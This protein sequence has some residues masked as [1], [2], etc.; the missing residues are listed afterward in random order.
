MDRN[1]RLFALTLLIACFLSSMV[2]T[3]A[4]AGQNQENRWEANSEKKFEITLDASPPVQYC[5]SRTAIQYYQD[6][7]NAK[8][9]GEINIDG[10]TNASGTY[11]ISVRFRD[12]NGKKR[13][14]GRN[15][16]RWTGWLE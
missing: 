2:A 4:P 11:T 3:S 12:E 14:K 15:L 1:L 8:V 13:K 6:D 9:D 5:E 10:C 16:P 7:K